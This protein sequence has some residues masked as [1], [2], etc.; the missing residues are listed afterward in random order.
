MSKKSDIAH[1]F[2]ESIAGYATKYG[3][4]FKQLGADD[5]VYEWLTLKVNWEGKN[6]VIEFIKDA[7][8]FINHRYFKF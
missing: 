4:Y 2:P 7:Q 6:G 3:N 1:Y 8:G 5:K